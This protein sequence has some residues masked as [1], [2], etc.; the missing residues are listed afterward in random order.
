MDAATN[1]GHGGKARSGIAAAAAVAM[2]AGT[3]LFLLSV[4]SEPER[5]VASAESERATPLGGAEGS[6]LV[7]GGRAATDPVAAAASASTKAGVG[8]ALDAG[9]RDV[10]ACT[11]LRAS[12]LDSTFGATWTAS[13]SSITGSAQCRWSVDGQ[14]GHGEPAEEVAITVSDAALYDRLRRLSGRHLEGLGDAALVSNRAPGHWVAVRVDDTTVFVAFSSAA[15]SAE[16][17][18]VALAREATA[19][20][21]GQARRG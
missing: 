3:V 4:D 13:P 21:L 5:E 2:L 20:F 19:A 11:L 14:Q 16:K 10:D 1:D 8:S 12:S 6:A 18:A 15:A 17:D 7:L 9:L